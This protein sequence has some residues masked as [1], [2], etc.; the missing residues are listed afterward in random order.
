MAIQQ[1]HVVVFVFLQTSP[2]LTQRKWL[3]NTESLP[4]IHILKSGK[5]KSY[6][7]VVVIYIV[8]TERLEVSGGEIG[9]EENI[10]SFDSSELLHTQA[11]IP[12]QTTLSLSTISSQ[13]SG[14]ISKIQ[15]CY[16]HFW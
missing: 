12:N 10:I 16:Y 2:N 1:K 3:D 4:D 14:I 11:F 6:H 7:V 13:T 5:N 15:S 9:E 8:F